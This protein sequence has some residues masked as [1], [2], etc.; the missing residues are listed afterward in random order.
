MV[1]GLVDVYD[2]IGSDEALGYLQKITDWAEKHLDRSNE[3]ALP[4]EWYTLSENLYRAYELT[5]DERYREFAKVW[6]YDRFWNALGRGSDLF[7]PLVHANKHP[8]YH[9]YS[10]VNSLSSA[11]MAYGVSGQQK[12]LDTIV[13]GYQ[14]LKET[15]LYATGGYGMIM[16]GSSYN[17]YGAQKSLSTVWFCCQGSLPQTVADYHNLIYFHDDEN[18]YVNLFAPSAVDWQGPGGKVR[19]VQET[20]FPDTFLRSLCSAVPS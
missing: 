17:L 18:L 15:Q 16:Y 1:G 14:F 3:Y 9:A 6:E 13:R 12:Y 10:H 5:G 8:S 19:I 20:R 4:S 11:A 7:R 2:Y